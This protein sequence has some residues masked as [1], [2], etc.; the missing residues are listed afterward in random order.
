VINRAP[1]SPKMSLTVG[2]ER[3]PGNR[4]SSDSRRCRRFDRMEISYRFSNR[5]Q[6]RQNPYS[7]RVRSLFYPGFTHS[8]S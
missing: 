7:M 1:G 6:E 5:S 3:K 2:L 4:Y 8:L